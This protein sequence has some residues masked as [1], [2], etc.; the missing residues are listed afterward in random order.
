[1]MA[2]ITSDESVIMEGSV[3]G[4]E[5]KWIRKMKEEVHCWAIY[6]LLK[7]AGRTPCLW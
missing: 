3:R 6:K 2:F 7:L 5:K 1:M 4:G